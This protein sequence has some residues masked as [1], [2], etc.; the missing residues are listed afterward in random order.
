MG[1]LRHIHT[2]LHRYPQATV[3]V[4]GRLR[5]AC[6]LSSFDLYLIGP[7]SLN[8]LIIAELSDHSVYIV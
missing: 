8:E 5:I 2:L 7:V 4:A 1:G 3:K 6:F